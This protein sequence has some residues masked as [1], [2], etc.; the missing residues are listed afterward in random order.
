MGAKDVNVAMLLL[1]RDI[2]AT[3]IS[4]IIIILSRHT[5]FTS[6]LKEWCFIWGTSGL[7][8]LTVYKTT[9]LFLF[10]PG[11]EPAEQ[12]N[13]TIGSYTINIYILHI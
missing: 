4:G 10:N 2:D 1:W 6:L 8:Q 11:A 5:D 13:T 7:H 12:A 9:I 3:S